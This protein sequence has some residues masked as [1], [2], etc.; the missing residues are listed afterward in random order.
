MVSV[1][2]GVFSLNACTSE[3]ELMYRYPEFHCRYNGQSC[4]G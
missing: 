4:L 3:A 2:V 1:K